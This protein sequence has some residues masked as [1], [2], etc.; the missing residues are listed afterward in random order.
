MTNHEI[1]TLFRHV[2]AAFAIKDEKKHYFQIVAYQKAADAIDNATSQVFDL[3]KE[4]KLGEI[5]GIGTTIKERLE[6]LVKKGKVAHFETVL[7]SVPQSMFP[8]LEV[9]S[10]GPKKAY[11]LV[12]AF[13]L[14]NSTTVINDVEKIAQEGKIAPLEGFG[15]KSQSDILRAI[16]EFR[17]GAGKTTRML[18]PFATEIAEKIV[19]YLK[20]S[21]AVKEAVPLGSLRRKKPTIGDVDIAVATDD[22]QKVLEHF[23]AYPY[24]DR[25]IEK[26]P[27]TSSILTSGGHQIDLMTMPVASFGSL[28]QHFSGSKQHNIHLRDFALRKGLSLSEYG[29][30]KVGE[31]D[32][33]KKP[34]K[35]EEEFY[36]A[37][38]LDWIPPELREDTGEI[39]RA[40]RQAQGKHPGLPKLVDLK[41]IKGDLHIHSAFPIEPSHDMGADS[42]E[43]MLKKA[44]LLGYEYLGF[45]EHNPSLNKH[46]EQ[47][48]CSL[49]QEKQEKIDQLNSSKKFIRAINLLEVDIQPDGKLAIPEKAFDYLDGAIVS[50]HSAFG[51]NKKEMTERVLAGLSHPKAKILAHPTGKLFNQRGGYDLDFEKVF[52]FCLK[53]HKALEINAWP[54][55][56]DLPDTLIRQAI[57]AGVKLVIDTDSH[58]VSHMD[59]M[60]YGVWNARR[61]WA[62][63]GDIL[64]TLEY[65]KFIEWLKR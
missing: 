7:A 29:I 54:D 33:K 55:R 56:T 43:D 49:I 48:I 58:A 62:E 35:T 24:K 59:V 17:K 52:E 23:V 60:I 11:K 5:P 32:D 16:G 26:G 42:M 40:L 38:G 27:N 46:T 4:N 10:F 45:S 2:A 30:K 44:E 20:E 51:L 22:P 64:N 15:E 28:L 3:V 14:K 21:S 41:D 19:M 34:Y 57:A 31:S 47:Q 1:A 13:K 37:L 18:L 6:E 36:G 61:G 12:T 50:V 53:H 9:P 63:K 39:E 25:V 65:T 8:L